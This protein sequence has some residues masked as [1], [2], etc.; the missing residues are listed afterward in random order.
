MG[1]K[2]LLLAW[3]IDGSW[4]HKNLSEI[5]ERNEEDAR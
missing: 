1:E 2:N 3:A 4:S 5:P